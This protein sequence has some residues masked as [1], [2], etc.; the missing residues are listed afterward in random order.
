VTPHELTIRS[1]TG[2]WVLSLVDDVDTS[3]TERIEA[4]IVGRTE[5]TAPLVVDLTEVTFLDSAGVRLM[6]RLAGRQHRAG[7]TVMIVAPTGGSPRFSLRM[8]EFPAD[9]LAETVETAL[10]M[11]RR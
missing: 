6:D 8:C 2:A 1:V 7:A 5:P 3:V 11:V 10:E 4:E 9:L